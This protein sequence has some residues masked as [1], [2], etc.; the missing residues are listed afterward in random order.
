MAKHSYHSFKKMLIQKTLILFVAIILFQGA[1]TWSQAAGNDADKPNVVLIAIDDLNDWIGCMGGHPQVKTPNIDRLADRGVLFTNAHCQSPVCNPSRASMMSGLFPE[2]TGIYFLSPPPSESPLIMKQV[3]MAQ[4][5]EKEGYY[6]TGAGKLFHNGGKQNETHIPNYGGN[7][8]G[9]G[10]IPK[11]KISSYPGHPLW[12][13]GVYPER[14]EMTPDHKVA[15]W[16]VKQLRQNREQ[17]LW[18]GVGFYRPHVPQFA[19]QKWFDMYPLDTLQLPVTMQDD[20]KDV[21]PYG[22]DLTRLKHVSPTMQWVQE[23]EQWKPLVQSYLACISF[24]DHQVG[25]ILDAVDASPKAGNTIVV[26]YTDHGFHLGEKDRFAKRSIW[27]DGAGVPMIIA[28]PGIGK[29]EVCG[30]PVQLI[31]IYPTLMDLIEAKPDASL[32]GHSLEPLLEN[33]AAEWLHVARSSFGPGNV[34]IVSEGYR[35]IHYNDG[36]EELYDRTADPHEWHNLAAAPEMASVLKQH[37]ADLPTSYH[38]VLGMGSTG[39]DAFDAAEK[40]NAK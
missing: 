31:D 16:G 14:D 1:T 24:V 5:F 6:A 12:D 4:R 21:P 15:S 39:H 26:L 33:P 9:F 27:Q 3:L 7:F 40:N 34:A 29:G 30:K 25:R 11:K 23:N 8:G 32:E 10:P 20:L 17:P 13:W 2:T 22:V 19:P 35:Y 28:G 18:L 36:S 38:P 37:R